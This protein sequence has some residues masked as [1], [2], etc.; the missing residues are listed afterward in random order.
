[1]QVNSISNSNQSFK[2]RVMLNLEVLNKAEKEA[3]KPVLNMAENSSIEENILRGFMA[4]MPEKLY[5]VF[6]KMLNNAKSPV[7]GEIQRKK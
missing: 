2:A 3:M 6:S 1:M 5:E 4:D 7:Q